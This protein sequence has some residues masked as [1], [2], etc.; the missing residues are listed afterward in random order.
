MNR[1]KKTAMETPQTEATTGAV[2]QPDVRKDGKPRRRGRTIHVKDVLQLLWSHK[3]IVLFFFLLIVSI[4]AIYTVKSPKV[5]RA[6]TKLEIKGDTVDLFATSGRRLAVD[7]GSIEYF[8]T[9][10]SKLKSRTVAENVIGLRRLRVTDPKTGEERPM[11]PSELLA[12]LKVQP[13]RDTRLVN[14]LVEDTDPK[15]AADIA[16][17]IV[18]EFIRY[19]VE[20][21][22]K[23]RTA[24]VQAIQKELDSYR[25]S[26]EEAE[27]AFNEFKQ[28]HKV[29]S[30]DKSEN[31]V[32][33]QLEAATRAATEVAAERAAAELAYEQIKNLALEELKTRPEIEK[34]S[35]FQQ[36]K[37]SL[38]T[39]SRFLSEASQRYG[40]K[41]PT[42]QEREKAVSNIQQSIDRRAEEVREQMRLAL[43]TAQEKEKKAA[44]AQNAA[45]QQVLE[46]NTTVRAQYQSLEMVLQTKQ[47]TYREGLQK[48]T[49][50]AMESRVSRA[51]TAWEPGTSNIGIV[52]RAVPSN[53]PVRPRPL[54][55]MALA[56]FIGLSLGCGSAFLLEY[57][58]DKV[59]NP[60]DVQED[61]GRPLLAMIPKPKARLRVGERMGRIIVSHPTSHAAEAYRNLQTNIRLMAR[62]GRFPS[63]LVTSACPGEGKTTTAENLAIVIAQHGYRVL[64]VDTDLRRPRIRRDFRI[65]TDKGLFA[66]LAGDCT[67]DEALV[68]VSKE[69]NIEDSAGGAPRAGRAELWVLPCE[70]RFPNPTE[71]VSSQKMQ[72]LAA[73]LRRRFDVVVFDSPPCQFADPLLLARY[74]DGVVAVVEAHKYDKRTVARGLEHLDKLERDKVFGIVLNKYDSKKSGGY[75]YY[76]YRSYYYYRYYDRYYYDYY[77]R[78]GK[79]RKGKKSPGDGN[80]PG[81]SKDSSVTEKP[82]ARTKA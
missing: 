62:D 60:D 38:D 65:Q 15:R 80:K 33:S 81:E 57:L 7:T 49:E 61:L 58:N 30:I 21:E 10:C 77:S 44:E 14:L 46:F 27:R 40:P 12:K 53:R 6:I 70:R 8:R 75:G 24:R 25:A 36:L 71:M 47:A 56:I 66:H 17:D 13:E 23:D 82:T 22:V 4:T 34:D 67:L 76:G 48:A 43:V 3:F 5:Y 16:N 32:L 72:D 26:V 11:R 29:V 35:V 45:R 39:A 55:N 1:E 2:A 73:E 68:N 42:Y 19:N 31:L 37:V 50:G 52:D 79:P 9:Q 74:V 64:L 51:P 18:D 20:R 59:K 63:L 69:T 28:R 78:A 54:I 41:H